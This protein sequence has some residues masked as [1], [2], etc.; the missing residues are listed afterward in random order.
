MIA[1]GYVDQEPHTFHS[2]STG[3]SK[4]EGFGVG[5]RATRGGRGLINIRIVSDVWVIFFH[6]D[7]IDH[8]LIDIS[9]ETFAQGP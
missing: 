9:I 4:V 1:N 2:S 3:R 8:K 7:P 6:L 5:I